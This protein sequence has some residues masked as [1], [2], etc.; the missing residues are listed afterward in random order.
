MTNKK[1]RENMKK[2][3]WLKRH[4]EGEAIL[5]EIYLSLSELTCNC[6]SVGLDMLGSKL[7]NM[8]D[9]IAI[10]RKELKESVNQMLDEGLK[11]SMTI[12]NLIN[13]L[14]TLKNYLT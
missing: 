2:N 1:E 7:N 6:F 9:K 11:R 4:H 8:S 5:D 10:A 3:D 12:V 14:I 13:T